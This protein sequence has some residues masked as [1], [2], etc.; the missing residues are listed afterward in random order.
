MATS[1]LALVEA[2]LAPGPFILG[3]EFSGADIMLGYTLLS[4]KHLGVLT[5]EFPNASRYLDL[6]VTRP[7][8]LKA[9]AA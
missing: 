1:A 4:A 2:A 7:A 5:P 8:L 9:I 3:T 6:L